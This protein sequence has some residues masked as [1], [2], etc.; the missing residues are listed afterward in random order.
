[1]LKFFLGIIFNRG[2]CVLN[3]NTCPPGSNDQWVDDPTYRWHKIRCEGDLCNKEPFK[4][5][6]INLK[7]Q[8]ACIF[9]NVCYSNLHFRNCRFDMY[10]FFMLWKTE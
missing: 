2:C 10:T 1:M 8:S 4:N 5:D 7:G 3:P 6:A 9:K